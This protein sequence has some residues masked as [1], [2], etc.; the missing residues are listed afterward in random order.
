M[1]RPEAG[2]GGRIPHH[3]AIIM[4][5]NGR[6]AQGR[7]MM[8]VAGHREGARAVRRVVEAAARMGVGIL[9]LFAF[10]SENWNRPGSEVGALMRL[11]AV[12]LRRERQG[13][14]DNGIRLRLIGRRERFSDSLQR[15]I[16]Q[17]EELTA[18]GTR[19]TLNIA[20]N[21]GGRLDLLE[22]V[23]R[24]E[25]RRAAG[26]LDPESLTESDLAAELYEPTD[27][28]LLI[29]T[30]GERRISNFLLW[31]CAYS[32]LYFTDT[33]W[34][35]FGEPDLSAAVDWYASRERRFGRTSAQ[36][37]EGGD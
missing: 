4:D 31:Q 34:P 14:L 23:R 2:P 20:A 12:A 26:G 19:M 15:A 25:R 5:G 35:D 18:G 33:L 36:V 11:F 21:Y 30:G 27:V 16:A 10:S 9:T 32:E 13:L 37:H 8:R 24:L 28:D 1:A 7:G 6:W 22:A 17:A 3:V 29:R